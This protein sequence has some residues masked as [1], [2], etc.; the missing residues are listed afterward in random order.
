MIF[1]LR[2]YDIHPGM[3]ENWLKLMQEHIH[4]F[5][6]QHGVAFIASFVVVDNPNKYIWIRRYSDQSERERITNDI[7][8][9]A[10]WKEKIKPLINEMLVKDSVKVTALK[11]T[12]IS[13][14]H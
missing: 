5:Q 12:D 2:E 7:Y 1:E 10:H 8:E 3:M 13:P 4:P 11:A 6:T 9:S 14:I